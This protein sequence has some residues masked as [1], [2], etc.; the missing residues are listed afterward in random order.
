MDVTVIE[1]EVD[2]VVEYQPA[3]QWENPDWDEVL[4]KVTQPRIA[5]RTATGLG[6]LALGLGF[7]EVFAP[8]AIGRL[9][10]VRP[11]RGTS[12]LTRAFGVRELATA[13]GV[14]G[15]GRRAPWLW[16]RVAGDVIDVLALGAALGRGRARPARVAGAMA[17]RLGVAALD[18][19]AAVKLG[20]AAPATFAGPMRQVTTIAASTEE[21][22][23]YW[24]NLQN[25]PSFMPRVQH[26]E[27]MPAGRTRWRARGPAGKVI[28]WESE[29]VEDVPNQ[30]IGWRSVEESPITMRGEVRFQPAPGMRGTEVSLELEYV[31]PAGDI[32]RLLAFASNDAIELQLAFD[33]RRLKQILEVGEIVHSDAS[34]HSGRHA[35]R[36][37]QLSRV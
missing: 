23:R 6:L 21:V 15:R 4:R 31:P 13:V 32:G 37:G 28:E 18:A 27:P 22:Y 2:G 11:R 19:Y 35:A 24:R 36:P 1:T 7:T 33:L 25:L 5:A 9:I 17:A 26:V 3:I 14:L 20:G 34:A 12:W 16:A 30:R 10:G 29:I 8:R